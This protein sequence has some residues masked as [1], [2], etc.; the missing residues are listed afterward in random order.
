MQI[1]GKKY[2]C[3]RCGEEAFVKR[4]EDAVLDG[5]FTREK[6]YEGI[7]GWTREKHG[8]AWCDLCPECTKQLQSVIGKFWDKNEGVDY[9]RNIIPC[10]ADR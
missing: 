7:D 1:E 8:S 3:D 5:G 6:I 9:E 10:K 4:K 2:I